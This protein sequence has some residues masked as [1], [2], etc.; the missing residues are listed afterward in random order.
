MQRLSKLQAMDS[1]CVASMPANAIAAIGSPDV[2]SDGSSQLQETN[3]GTFGTG[4]LNDHRPG[5]PGEG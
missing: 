2:K 1:R 4:I 3:N 5:R